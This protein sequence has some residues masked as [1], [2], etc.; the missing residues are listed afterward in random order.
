[1][2]RFKVVTKFVLKVHSVPLNDGLAAFA[3]C[4]Q[5]VTSNQSPV[6]S[7]L[8]LSLS[9]SLYVCVSL[10]GS[11]RHTSNTFLERKEHLDL[12]LL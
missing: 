11:K 5:S 3:P 8:S 7:S 12:Q 9:L 4:E 10:S 1:V 6:T 2:S